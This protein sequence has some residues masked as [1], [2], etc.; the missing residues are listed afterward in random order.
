MKAEGMPFRSVTE[1]SQVT[2]SV[3]PIPRRIIRVSS[4]AQRKED[5][6]PLDIPAKKI[7]IS[8]IRVGNLPLQGTKLLVRMARRRSLS[9]SMIRQPVTPAAL[10][11]N[12][13]AMH[14]ACFPQAW[15]HWNGLSRL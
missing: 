13:M 9:E 12:P 10:Q 3:M 4:S 1:S 7:A 5:Q 14:S 15:Q 8:A 6:R 2:A 11:P